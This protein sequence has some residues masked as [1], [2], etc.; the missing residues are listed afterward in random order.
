MRSYNY[1]ILA[2]LEKND[3]ESFFTEKYKDV[4][5][6]EICFRRELENYKLKKLLKKNHIS[7]FL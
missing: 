2:I 6:L 4:L 3:E 5:K 7:K 1:K